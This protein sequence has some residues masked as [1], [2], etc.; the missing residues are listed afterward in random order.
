MTDQKNDEV[1]HNG[2][3]ETTASGALALQI[4]T[5]EMETGVFSCGSSFRILGMKRV[6]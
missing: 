4:Q 6:E 2:R 1:A 3:V 5:G